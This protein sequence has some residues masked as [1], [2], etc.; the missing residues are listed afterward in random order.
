VQVNV[1]I[2]GQYAGSDRRVVKEVL[3]AAGTDR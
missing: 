2:D 3:Q 1:S